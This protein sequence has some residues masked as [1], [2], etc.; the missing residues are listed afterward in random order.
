M[1]KL[2][3]VSVFLLFTLNANAA[4]VWEIKD[5]YVESASTFVDLIG[6][7]YYNVI[8]IKL[9]LPIHTG[10]PVSDNDNVVSLW[11]GGGDP[12]AASNSIL[13]TALTAKATGQKVDIFTEDTTCSSYYGRY[14]VGIR[15]DP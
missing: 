8:Q 14:W 6:S 11:I 3:L 13:S 1:K 12:T 5:N 9:K 4:R 10:C 15:L 2:M 7:N